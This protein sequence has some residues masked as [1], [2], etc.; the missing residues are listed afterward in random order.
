[1]DSTVTRRSRYHCDDISAA[2]IS[3]DDDRSALSG[4]LGVTFMKR[5]LM[6]PEDIA[7]GLQ[8]KGFVEH[9]RQ[10]DNV[11]MAPT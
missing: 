4:T 11:P 10:C 6:R 2:D 8:L 5:V 1:V 9:E 7:H 3:A